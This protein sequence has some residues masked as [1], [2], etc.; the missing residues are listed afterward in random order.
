[1]PTLIENIWLAGAS[2][3]STI[4]SIVHSKH[5][6]RQQLQRRN[7]VFVYIYEIFEGPGCSSFYTYCQIGFSPGSVYSFYQITNI[8]F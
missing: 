8:P 5:C 7:K 2:H 6:T 1:M 4:R 3:A